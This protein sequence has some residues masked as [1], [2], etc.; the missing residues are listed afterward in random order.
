MLYH[1]NGLP[2][3]AALLTITKNNELV[4]AVTEKSE[5]FKSRIKELILDYFGTKGVGLADFAVNLV[6]AFLILIIGLKAVKYLVRVVRKIFVKSRMDPTLQTFLLSFMSISLKIL[7]IFMAVSKIGVG[8]SSIVALLGSAGLAVGL[9]L[10]GSL[11]NIAGGVILLL[12]KPF[13]VGDYIMEE[14]TGK[15]GTVEAIGM[16]YTKLLTLDNKAVMVPNGN[17]AN[18]SITNYTHQEKRIVDLKIGVSYDTDIDKVKE[19]LMKIVMDEKHLVPG[20]PIKIFIN[21]YLDS[22]IQMGLRY[23][24]VTAEYWTSRWYVLERIKKEFE[25][26]GIVIPF[27]QLDVHMV[28]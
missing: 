21:D 25:K 28:K 9:S 6:V 8:A 5:S 3:R 19:I 17:L 15:E 16:I 2:Y 20:E 14:S 24:V 11:G 27:N 26:N 18:S 12:I 13:E 10:Q 7:V 23:T 1:T 22:S 4:D